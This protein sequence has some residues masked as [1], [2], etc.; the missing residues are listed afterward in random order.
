[1]AAELAK[2]GCRFSIKPAEALDVSR[3]V[4]RENESFE[5]SKRQ[6]VAN[7]EMARG[8]LGCL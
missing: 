7:I 2:A 8:T 6:R 1:M 5:S 3:I 4:E